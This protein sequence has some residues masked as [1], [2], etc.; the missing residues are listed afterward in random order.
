V[1][2][3][4]LL[5]P[6]LPPEATASADT[7]VGGLISSN[8]TWTA[9][10]SPYIVASSVLV[11]AGVTLTIEPGVTVKFDSDK[12]L[13]IDGQ[14]IARGT[15]VAPIIFTSNQTSP[16]PGGWVNIVFSDSSV[17]AVYDSNGDYVDGSIMQ[18]STVEYGG[19]G[20]MPALKLVSC[21]P[22]VD[23]CVIAH[24]AYTG[25]S[26]WP[27]SPRI[28]NSRVNNNS[29]YY[30]GGILAYGGVMIVG[31]VISNNTAWQGGG[32][33]GV[34]V[35][36]TGNI[37]SNNSAT[38]GGGIYADDSVISYNDIIGNSATGGGGGI[39]I[40]PSGHPLINYN[41]IYGNTLYDVHDGNTQGSPIVNCTNNWWGTTNETEIQAHIYDWYD[42]ATLGIVDYFPYLTEPVTPTLVEPL[43]GQ[44]NPPTDPD[45]D[46]V[47]EDLNSNGGKDFDDVVKFFKY[48][49]WIGE[50]EPVSCFD[51]NGNGVIDFD[52]LVKLFKE[53]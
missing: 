20:N 26:V 35:T 21:S 3:A 24:N 10:G 2:V 9:A 15:E 4:S 27:G 8:T 28:S 1:L 46:G 7:I 29:G 36:I 50:N 33:S 37:I 32:I 6:L 49:E 45:G 30:G 40:H 53:I 34:G 11:V 5:S 18:Y 23:H 16:V 14:L 41:N 25:I 13:Q 12:G 31:N 47:Y 39:G 44:A 51:F 52:D 19:G 48:L 43:P 22:L 38:D 17:D 42:D